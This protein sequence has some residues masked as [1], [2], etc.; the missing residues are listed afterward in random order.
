ML[1]ASIVGCI[2]LVLLFHGSANF[3]EAISASKYPDYVEY[4]KRVRRFI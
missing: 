4:I 2:L 3:S 1:N